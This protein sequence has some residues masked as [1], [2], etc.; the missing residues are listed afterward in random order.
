MRAL[1]FLTELILV[2][3][4]RRVYDARSEYKAKDQMEQ[5][6]ITSLKVGDLILAECF[7]VRREGYGS[8]TSFFSLNAISL[9]D[10]RGKGSYDVADV[11]DTTFPWTI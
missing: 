7:F 1:C 3:Y 8:T 10:D 9:L 4:L 5:L 11:Q 6:N 2:Q